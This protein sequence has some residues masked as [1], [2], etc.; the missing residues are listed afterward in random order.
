VAGAAIANH[1]DLDKVAFTG[2][3]AVGKMVMEAAAKT[4]LKR[5]S[6]E[7]GGKSPNIVFADAD[8]ELAVEKSHFGVFFNMGQCCC[9]GTRIFVEEAAYDKFVE[10]S[11]ERA[12]KR[13]VGDPFDPN[14]EQGPQVS[15]AQMTKIL[16]LIDSG[17]REGAKLGVGGARIGD[18]GYFVAPTVFHGVQDQMTIAREEIFGPV[19]QI[20]KFK[21]QDEVIARA[22]NSE[23]GLASSVFTQDIDKA[24][25]ISHALRAGTVW[26]NTYDDFDPT[27]P[28]GGYKQSGHGREKGEDSLDSYCE[29]KTV[30]IAVPQKNS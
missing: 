2:S 19:M 23:Y 30:S 18:K 13:T 15:E 24:M 22:N 12:K 4:N 9:A 1:P 28:F 5:V 20:M 6:L 10:A 17:R 3:T 14:I 26:V 8:M 29:V 11:I 7:L 16:G 27:A 25:H 21:T